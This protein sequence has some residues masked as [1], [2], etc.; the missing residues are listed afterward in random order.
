MD[1]DV[2]KTSKTEVRRT[3]RRMK[4]GKAVGPDDIRVEL[5]KCLVEAAVKF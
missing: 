2:V 1:Q 3:L 5:W 4:S